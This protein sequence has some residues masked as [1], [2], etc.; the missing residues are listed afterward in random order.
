[1]KA[2]LLGCATGSEG[3]L[4][5]DFLPASSQSTQY[6]RIFAYF[7]QDRLLLIFLVGLIW[8]ALFLGVLEPAA[9]AALTDS[10][11]GHIGHEW[12]S[13]LLMWL[14]P[15]GRMS[16]V[17]GL[18]IIWLVVRAANDTITLAREMINNQLRYNGTAR[19]R[20]QLFDHFQQLTPAYHKTHPLGDAIYRLGTDALGFFGVLDTFVGAANSLLTLVVISLVMLG[21]NVKLTLLALGLAPLLVAANAYFSR[22]IR[23]TSAVSKQAD[24]DLTSFIQ[25]AIAA[26]SLVQ[27]FGREKTQSNRL[28]GYINR[29]IRAG[30]TM[31]WQQQIYPWIQ[32]LIYAV[33][34]AFVLGFGGYL[35]VAGGGRADALTVGGVFAMTFY[36]SQLWEPLRRITGFTADVQNNAA[37]C[38]RV[39][40]VL[41]LE[42]AVTDDPT[43]KPLKA[44]PS[45][46]TLNDVYFDYHASRPVLSGINGRIE[47]GEMVGFVGASGAGKSTLL[48]LLPR[49][50]DPTRGSISLDGHDLRSLRL[51]DVRW[52]IA[53]VP[54]DSPVIAGTIAEN[55]AFG[56][57]S[58]SFAEIRHAAEL[59]GAAEFIDKLPDGFQTIIREGGQNLSGGQRQRLAIA[60]VLLTGAPILVFDEPT[61]GLDRSHELKILSTLERLKATHAVILVTH[62]LT[63]AERCDRIFFL[64]NGR[65]AEQ[66][67]HMELLERGG[68]YAALAAMPHLV[69]ETVTDDAVDSSAHS[70]A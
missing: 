6:K 54:Q 44:E 69:E 31:S 7:K 14:T 1:M 46:L 64:Q 61:S 59:A 65:V 55:I 22:T 63:A 35:V 50:Y 4:T 38:A 20:T 53:L 21:W 5:D 32:R 58:A 41:D 10:L 13:R 56:R 8:V 29:T 26:I 25:W 52:Q 3:Q 15:S 33:G 60:R 39:F 62:S 17:I 30:M 16:R 19:V 9:V 11:A 24:S 49:F 28:E 36:L 12:H 66:G 57:P 70:A 43:A 40:N 37:A 67:T 27:L 68:A 23:K 47:R 34:Y 51:S 45:V 2:E 42:P 48:S 18:G